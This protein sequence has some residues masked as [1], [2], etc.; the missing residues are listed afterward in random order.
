MNKGKI[1]IDRC[2]NVIVNEGGVAHHTGWIIEDAFR[3][4]GNPILVKGIGFMKKTGK[5]WFDKVIFQT[6]KEK[7]SPSFSLQEDNVHITVD[8]FKKLTGWGN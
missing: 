8:D 1:C 6:K 2:L 4:N 7:D 3:I 5:R